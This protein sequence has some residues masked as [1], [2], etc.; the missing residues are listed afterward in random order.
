MTTNRE[1]WR[2]VGAWQRRIE[3]CEDSQF[4]SIT[5][6]VFAL[7]AAALLLLRI[8]FT[9]SSPDQVQKP[10]NLSLWMSARGRKG[11]RGDTYRRSRHCLCAEVAVPSSSSNIR[12][13]FICFVHT[14]Q[15]LCAGA[16]CDVR[17]RR[18][19]SMKSRECSSRYEQNIS[20]S[21]FR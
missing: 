1:P 19:A 8:P 4:R 5:L 7:A 15:L 12:S 11:T 10:Q 14:L 17:H 9:T 20:F 13:Y 3:S 2:C 21:T 6:Y 16:E 18:A